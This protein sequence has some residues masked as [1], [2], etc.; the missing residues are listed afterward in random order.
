MKSQIIANTIL[1]SGTGDGLII[2]EEE[3]QFEVTI[4]PAVELVH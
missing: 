4:A 2:Y 3:E 1:W